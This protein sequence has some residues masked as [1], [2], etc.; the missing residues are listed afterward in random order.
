MREEALAMDT[1]PIAPPPVQY[2]GLG[3]TIFPAPSPNGSRPD[4]TS[5]EPEG[6]TNPPSSGEELLAVSTDTAPVR[7]SIA[8]DRGL[9][10][11]RQ[12]QPVPDSGTGSRN[13]PYYR[14]PVPLPRGNR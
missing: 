6:L 5:P 10:R 8:L 11:W 13:R 4:P 12:N 9:E 1:H 3:R 7:V 2:D 14:F